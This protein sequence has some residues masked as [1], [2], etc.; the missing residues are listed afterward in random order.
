M[1]IITA[2]ENRCPNCNRKYLFKEGQEYCFHCDVIEKEDEAVKDEASS[3]IEKRKKDERFKAFKDKS[4]INPKLELA[5]FENYFPQNESQEQALSKTLQF[6]K[7]FQTDK[8]LWLQ[9][10]PGLGKSH[11]SAS[12]AKEVMNQGYNSI[13]ISLPRLMTEIRN[14]YN[15]K[16]E[17]TELDIFKALEAVDLLILDDIGAEKTKEDEGLSWSKSKIFEIVDSRIGKATVYTTNYTAKE[18]IHMYGER[19]F[20]RMIENAEIIVMNGEN[21]RLKAFK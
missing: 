6:A 13:F 14:T 15:R 9:G 1:D 17:H 8:S 5:T 12:I 2:S 16:S 3:W 21:Y 4:L 11:L 7:E 20:S 19:D 10:R 18:L